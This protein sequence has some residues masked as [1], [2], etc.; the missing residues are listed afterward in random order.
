MA[1]RKLL[2]SIEYHDDDDTGMYKIGEVDYGYGQE[3]HNYLKEFGLEGRNNLLQTLGF[4]AYTT[5]A[6]YLKTNPPQ[7]GSCE[8][9]QDRP[10]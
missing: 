8:N 1:S 6:I 2:I 4:L 9:R 10:T 7:M 3:L 5:Q